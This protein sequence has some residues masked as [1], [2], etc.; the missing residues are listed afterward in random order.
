MQVMKHFK[1]FFYLI[2]YTFVPSFFPSQS[3][4]PSPPHPDWC[5]TNHPVA[6]DPPS[7]TAVSQTHNCSPT[8]LRRHQDSF[9]NG[10]T[11]I[12]SFRVRNL[13]RDLMR[14]SR[15]GLPAQGIGN[16]FQKMITQIFLTL[17][18]I[19]NWYGP[20]VASLVSSTPSSTPGPTTSTPCPPHPVLVTAG[21]S[22][23]SS[24]RVK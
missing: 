8:R 24:W 19:K 3:A 2:V 15:K 11:S 1:S 14:A 6:G 13:Q 20:L 21:V 5:T 16:I 22:L 10:T 23:P 9:M 4:V 12:T 7:L 18:G 17:P